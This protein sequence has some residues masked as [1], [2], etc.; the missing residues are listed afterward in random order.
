VKQILAE[1]SVRKEW[2]SLQQ[3]E[4]HFDEKK[5]KQAEGISRNI[6]ERSGKIIQ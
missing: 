1:N 5:V 4:K 3:A 6:S 2:D